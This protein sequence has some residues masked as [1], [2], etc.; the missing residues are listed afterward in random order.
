M[1]FD[2]IPT[3]REKFK[4]PMGG[5]QSPI[6]GHLYCSV[7]T[8]FD[9]IIDNSHGAGHSI[10]AYFGVKRYDFDKDENAIEYSSIGNSKKWKQAYFR[11]QELIEAINNMGD[12]IRGSRVKTV[13]EYF[14][15][16]QIVPIGSDSKRVTVFRK[17]ALIG[18]N[19]TCPHCGA[20]IDLLHENYKGDISSMKYQDCDISEKVICPNSTCGKSFSVSIKDIE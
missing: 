16:C 20:K 1:R 11:P 6:D 10:L 8:S 9:L 13:V 17:I 14:S 2:I 15:C 18:L 4:V 12:N 5:F 3:N 19:T 7:A